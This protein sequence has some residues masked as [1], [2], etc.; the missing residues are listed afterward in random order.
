MKFMRK[1]VQGTTTILIIFMVLCYTCYAADILFIDRS[2]AGPT[3]AEKQL[4]IASR[5]YGLD[6]TILKVDGT[7][8]NPKAK[9]VVTY[10]EKH[11]LYREAV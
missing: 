4:E 2:S 3:V 1:M 11:G 5:F 6:F 8:G 10:I 9:A 7:D